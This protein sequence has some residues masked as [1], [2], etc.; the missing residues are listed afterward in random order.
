MKTKT[1]V[2]LFA[3]AIAALTIAQTGPTYTPEEA[4][5]LYEQ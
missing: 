4:A 3:A 5:R 2:A 1:T